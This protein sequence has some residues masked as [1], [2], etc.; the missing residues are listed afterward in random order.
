VTRLLGETNKPAKSADLDDLPL[1]STA[2]LQRLSELATA[3][4][5]EVVRRHTAGEARWQGYE[6][7]EIAAARNL[8]STEAPVIAR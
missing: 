5:S 7:S 8:L 3:K 2:T 1:P 6:E 4:L